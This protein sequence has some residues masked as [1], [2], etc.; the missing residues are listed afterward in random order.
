MR[1]MG[2]SLG[3]A[4]FGAIFA[5]RLHSQLSA[6]PALAA[7]HLSGGVNVSPAQVHA[8]APAVRHQFLQAFVHALSPVFL[9]GAALT[10]V[11]FVLALLLKEVPLQSSLSDLDEPVAGAASPAAFVAR[12]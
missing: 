3:V 10:A 5:A 6:L 7:S 4:L 12:S 2:G 11:A 1:S 9:V 8:L